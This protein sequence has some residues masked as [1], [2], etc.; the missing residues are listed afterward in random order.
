M[1]ILLLILTAC[2]LFGSDLRRC[3]GL[4]KVLKCVNNRILI[5]D[6]LIFCTTY[7]ASMTLLSSLNSYYTSLNSYCEART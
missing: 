5:S 6:Y 7:I 3:G 1:Q 4:I 2:A